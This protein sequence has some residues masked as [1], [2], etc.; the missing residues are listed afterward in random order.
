MG[1][2]LSVA[3][4]T[5]L[6]TNVPP[7]RSIDRSQDKR[8]VSRETVCY[9][10]VLMATYGNMLTHSVTHCYTRGMSK[11]QTA[12]QSF[13]LTLTYE[14]LVTLRLTLTAAAN[15]ARAEAADL[16]SRPIADDLTDKADIL[17]CIRRN[18]NTSADAQSTARM[19]RKV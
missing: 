9:T 11:T 2:L 3:R 18:L 10:F 5:G 17:D 7:G 13:T 12:P 19:A 8:P 4:A 16:G 1:K 15:R 6:R 14:E